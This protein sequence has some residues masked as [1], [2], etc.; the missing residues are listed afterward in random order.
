MSP[1]KH[2]LTHTHAYPALLG[3][4]QRQEGAA[5]YLAHQQFRYTTQKDKVI[6]G[7]MVTHGEFMC[8]TYRGS[9]LFTLDSV[10]I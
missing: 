3:G 9:L 4:R 5:V 1:N 8:I 6:D 2:T 7:E 10:F